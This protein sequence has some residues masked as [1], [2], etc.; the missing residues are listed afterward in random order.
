MKANRGRDHVGLDRNTNVPAIVVC[1]E[2]DCTIVRRV[3]TAE[4]VS[5]HEKLS[6]CACDGAAMGVAAASMCNCL[7]FVTVLLCCE[8]EMN[9]SGRL[10]IGIRRCGIAEAATT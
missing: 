9:G 10:D 8:G 2:F 1:C 3:G 4:L 6:Y 5:M 7:A